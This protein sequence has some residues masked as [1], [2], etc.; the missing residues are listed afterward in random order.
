MDSNTKA[1]VNPAIHDAAKIFVGGLSWQTTE[2]NLRYHFEQYGEVISVEI[3]KDRNTG[4]PRGFAFVVFKEDSYVQLVLENLPHVINHKV[5]DVKRA[6][7]RGTAPPS[8]HGSIPLPQPPPPTSGMS[9][10]VT[11]DNTAIQS[12]QNHN[13]SNNNITNTTT[14]IAMNH[15]TTAS[16]TTTFHGNYD[17]VNSGGAVNKKEPSPEELQ[18]K[19]FVGG[20]PL[21]IGS[22]QLGEFFS[23]FGTVVDAIVMMDPMQQR[24][25]GF[26]FVTFEN[27]TF[28]AQKCLAAQPIYIENKYVEI[29]L[30]TPKGDQQGQAKLRYQAAAPGSLRNAAA[31]IVAAASHMGGEYAGLAASYG[32]NGWRAGY[33]TKAFG[34]SGWGVVGWEESGTTTTTVLLEPSGFSFTKL[35]DIIAAQQQEQVQNLTKTKSDNKKHKLSI[36]E[37]IDEQR[38]MKKEK[39]K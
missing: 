8:I 22:D 3:M 9:S 1:G 34:P 10:T 17:T 16:S 11:G 29:K 24:S 15:T 20:L 25:R 18:N 5:V 14:S 21:H 7:A 37:I 23:Q 19:I 30:A 31:A 4:D 27:G 2:E 38:P 35:D 13:N 33:G 12:I 26:G 32:R 6:Q 28:G 36:S 39:V